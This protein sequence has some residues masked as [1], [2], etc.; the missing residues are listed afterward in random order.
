[1]DMNRVG[2]LED[3]LVYE[4]PKVRVY[5]RG[6]FEGL[7]GTGMYAHGSQA[8][9]RLRVMRKTLPSADP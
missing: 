9:K 8:S 7:N 5:N 4:A 3:K 6:L 2:E 1:M